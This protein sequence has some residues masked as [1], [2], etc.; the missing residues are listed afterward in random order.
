MSLVILSDS[1][2]IR[3][4]L[5]WMVVIFEKSGP[6]RSEQKKN[7]KTLV[8]KQRTTCTQHTQRL[9]LASTIHHTLVSTLN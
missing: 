4:G 1:T 5:P 7:K 2:S 6:E 8:P 9:E 3:F